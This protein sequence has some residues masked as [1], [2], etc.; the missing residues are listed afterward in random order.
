[1]EIELNPLSA[2]HSTLYSVLLRL[3]IC[4]SVSVY[5]L[6]SNF[7]FLIFSILSFGLPSVPQ[8]V[9]LLV[10]AVFVAEKNAIDTVFDR[11]HQHHELDCDDIAGRHSK[12]MHKHP[13][14]LPVVL[15]K[16]FEITNRSG[17]IPGADVTD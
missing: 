15:R 10:D 11:Q 12:E 1:M 13:V 6:L 5:S 9:P 7:S 8:I 3:M 14:T 17:N 4:Y 2:V 16:Q